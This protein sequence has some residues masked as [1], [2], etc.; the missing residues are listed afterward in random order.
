M[1]LI[2]KNKTYR[3]PCHAQLNARYLQLK[4]KILRSEWK[5][6]RLLICYTKLPT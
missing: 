6:K 4:K 2:E 5:G 3:M 1:Q